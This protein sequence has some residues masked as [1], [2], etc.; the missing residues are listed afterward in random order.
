M[1]I[2]V[3]NLER[4][5]TEAELKGVFA[6]FGQVTSASIVKDRNGQSR[7][8]AFVEMPERAEAEAALAGLKGQML[9]ERTLDISEAS[10]RDGHAKGAHGRGHSG[11]FSR[12]RRRF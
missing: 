7:G 5:V 6:A 12:G 2:Y 8:F 1:N 4:D 9:K 10:P 11:G 3:G